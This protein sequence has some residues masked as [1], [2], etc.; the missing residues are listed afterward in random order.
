MRTEQEMFDLILNTARED[1]RIRAVWMNG[2]R[3]NPNARQDRY[4]DFDIVYAVSVLEPF[5]D[6][7]WI[8]R[9]GEIC[10][11]QDPDGSPFFAPEEDY[12]LG[13][14]QTWLMQFA[15][16]NRLD[17]DVTLH[18]DGR[19]V[20]VPAGVPFGLMPGESLTLEPLCYH[21]FYAS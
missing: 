6:P 11:M 8:G 9:F 15:D 4:M 18:R 1:S 2:S 12:R 10:V 16:G 14:R 7:D 17:T 5:R 21:A 13:Q 3:A 19:R 20:T